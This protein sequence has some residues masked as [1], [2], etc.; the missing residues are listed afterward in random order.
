MVTFL[1]EELWRM[2]CLKLASNPPDDVRLALEATLT[3]Q[4]VGCFVSMVGVVALG[5]RVSASWAK[6]PRVS[7][8]QK[9]EGFIQVIFFEAHME[10]WRDLWLVDKRYLDTRDYCILI[11]STIMETRFAKANCWMFVGINVAQTDGCCQELAMNLGSLVTPHVFLEPFLGYSCWN[12][13][14]KKISRTPPRVWMSFRNH[15]HIIL[16]FQS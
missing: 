11:Q 4:K 6:G 10:P 2:A 13:S 9:E 8:C 15:D 16:E 3:S 1:V 12:L 7:K 5:G 14:T